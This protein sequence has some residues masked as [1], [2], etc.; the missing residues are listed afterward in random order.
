MIE[1]NDTLLSFLFP[2]LLFHGPRE[3]KKGK[4]ATNQLDYMQLLKDHLM[5]QN[6]DDHS[7][8]AIQLGIAIEILSFLQQY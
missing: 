6:N 5:T 7:S 3:G 4:H 8:A 2:I 1:G